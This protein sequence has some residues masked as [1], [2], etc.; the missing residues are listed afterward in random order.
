MVKSCHVH[1]R[2]I[3]LGPGIIGMLK[4][5]VITGRICCKVQGGMIY[6]RLHLYFE[7]FGYWIHSAQSSEKSQPFL[8]VHY[9]D[10]IM[11]AIT[12]QITSLTIVY[13]TVYS[14]LEQRKHQSS[15]SLAFVQGIRR[16][17]VNSPHKGPVTRKLFPFDDVILPWGGSSDNHRLIAKATVMRCA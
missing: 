10:V 7:V 14:S 3:S 8:P 5:S 6:N 2:A 17:P 13:S 11:S 1:L 4:I 12:S 16:G 9:N 15:A